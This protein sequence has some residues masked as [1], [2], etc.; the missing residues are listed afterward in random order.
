MID[1]N[2]M[3]NDLKYYRIMINFFLNCQTTFLSSFFFFFFLL[4]ELPLQFTK[5]YVDCFFFNQVVVA[6]ID[7]VI[8]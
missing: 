7:N 1:L 5:T 8:F 2:D 4:L 6:F 3:R